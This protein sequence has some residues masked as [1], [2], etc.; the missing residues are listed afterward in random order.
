V[1]HVGTGTG[2]WVTVATR[3]YADPCATV[4]DVF[5]WK[6]FLPGVTDSGS[7]ISAGLSIQRHNPA[8]DTN[9]CRETYPTGDLETQASNG[10]PCSIPTAVDLAAFTATGQKDGILLEWETATEVDNL[11]FTLYVPLRR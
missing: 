5:T 10:T 6:W 2:A 3:F 11:G 1:D 7:D 9:D 4:V 8:L